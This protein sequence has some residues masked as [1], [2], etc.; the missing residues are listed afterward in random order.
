M[1][2]R[3]PGG[4]SAA[5]AG[6]LLLA[7]AIGIFANNGGA[8]VPARVF[9][10]ASR[11]LIMDQGRIKPL[12]V[13]ARFTLYE[14]SGRSSI[15]KKTAIDWLCRLALRPEDALDDPVFLIDDPAVADAIG[16]APAKNRRYSLRTLWP[17]LD[18][19]E[20]GAMKTRAMDPADRSGVDIELLRLSVNVRKLLDLPG[21]LS[22]SNAMR[23]STLDIF[24]VIPLEKEGSIVWQDPPGWYAAGNGLRAADSVV[25]ELYRARAAYSRSDFLECATAIG[26]ANKLVRERLR[27]HGI[28]VRPELELFYT[29]LDPFLWARLAYA[30]AL[31][32]LIAGAAFSRM[33]IERP[34]GFAIA[35]GF[36]LHTAGLIVRMV[37]LHRPPVATFYETFVFVAW[38]GV[39]LGALVW[40]FQKR[41]HGLFIAAFLGLLFLF[42]STRFSA[43]SDTMG[44]LAPVLN[45]NFWLTLHIVT[46]VTGYAGCLAAGVL[47]HLS[48]LQRG[49]PGRF[50]GGSVNRDDHSLQRAMWAMLATGLAFTTLGTVLGGIWA[51]QAWGRFWGWD[52]KENGALVIILWCAILFHA[53]TGGF[54][55]RF[56][57]AFGIA[58][59]VPLVMLAWVGVNLLG[60]GMHSY[61][62]TAVGARILL[63]TL[64]ADGAF[65]AFLATKLLY[66]GRK[67]RE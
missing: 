17:V 39:L 50:D 6:N 35:G 18:K 14:L 56:D 60:I 43:G 38:S 51:E 3:S 9:K 58:C 65:M 64:G 25:V 29:S 21:A 40:A 28:T 54:T 52:P 55:R 16:I 11:M 1:P 57:G 37:I 24:P 27:R 61:G 20:F 48:L 36:L 47:G 63:W 46:I 13:Y 12:A 59:C 26:S 8:N 45:S 41:T 22:F 5:L 34:A 32:L 33:G 4:R 53:R 67:T 49:F 23:D 7:A 31:L 62:F 2:E 10:E 19:I 42:F 44:M 66:H 15:G 30:L